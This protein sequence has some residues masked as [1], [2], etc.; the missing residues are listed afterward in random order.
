MSHS[1]SQPVP[2]GAYTLPGRVSDP[3]VAVGQA[4]VA[5]HLGLETI[6]ISER[7]GTKDVGVLGGAIAAS[8]T[9]I[10]IASG[11]AHFLFRHPLVLAGMAMTLQ[12]LSGGRFILGVGRS[13]GPMWTAVGL[14][15]MTNQAL[16]DCADIHRRLCR[17]ER[18]KYDGP[19]GR[20]P[21][22]R[23]GDLP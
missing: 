10:K 5:E 19:A 9:D 18:V 1:S 3:T 4:K 23:L 12:A 8:T 13:V 21:S 14:P 2:L 16:V 17:G 7:Y 6:W 15:K 20:F 22:L 11:V